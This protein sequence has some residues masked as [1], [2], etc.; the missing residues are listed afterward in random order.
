MKVIQVMFD[1]LRKDYLTPY[2]A[3][4]MITPNFDRVAQETVRFDNFFAGSLPCMPARRELHTG[5]YNFLHRGWGPVEPFDDSMPEILRT[6]G[7]YTHLVT[8]H[9]HYWRDGGSTYH[10]R[11]SSYEFIRGQEGDNWK[12]QVDKNADLSGLENLN[13][14]QK[15]R[16]VGSISQDFVNR[17]YMPRIEDHPLHR[18][19]EAGLDFLKANKDA[20]QWFLQ[21]ECFDPH[22]PFFVP[23]K[24]LDMYNVPEEFNGWLTYTYDNFTPEKRDIILGYYKALIT[25][26]DDYLGKVLDFMDESNLWDDTMLIVNTDH[27]F[28]LGEHEWWGKN[29]M[30]V[31]NEIANIP[32]F[33]WDPRQKDRGIGTECL[34]QTI[35]IPSTILDFFN[36]DL[37][38]DMK[39]KPVGNI[40]KNKKSN[41]DA[42]LFGYFGS[43]INITDGEYVYMRAPLPNREEL[44][45]E[46]TLS[47]MRIN[48]RFNNKELSNLSLDDSFSFTKGISV[49]KI[50]SND[51]MA[52]NYQRFGNKLYNYKNDPKQLQ[53]LDDCAKEFELITKM[54]QLMK[55]NEAPPEL[56]TYYGLDNIHSVEDVINE[57]KIQEVQDQLLLDGLSFMNRSSKEGFLVLEKLLKEP[58]KQEALQTYFAAQKQPIS[59]EALQKWVSQNIAADEQAFIYYQLNLAM[60]IE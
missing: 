11:Y 38:A 51:I 17:A 43:N 50:K 1:T 44:L 34:S 47:P 2:G 58:L 28:M 40:T 12:A 46:Y 60:R 35:D 21:I 55:E 59:S 3:T 8:D 20:D 13:A 49:L 52:E 10:P 30:P 6:N 41:H 37:P 31:Y 4:N 56:Y 26:C 14:E 54:K 25:M 29:I 15:K 16:K 5:R 42:V 9:K 22:E 19:V 33:I 18:T 32:F 48:R 45:H 53:P 36:I 27:G 24:Y 39:G 7:I 23:K 57:H